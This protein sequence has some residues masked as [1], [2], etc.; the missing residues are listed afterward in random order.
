MSNSAFKPSVTPLAWISFYRAAYRM[1]T[2]SSAVLGLETAGVGIGPRLI[3]RNAD[4]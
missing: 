4:S 2:K 1:S 3:E